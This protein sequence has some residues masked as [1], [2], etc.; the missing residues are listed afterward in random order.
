MAVFHLT[1]PLYVLPNMDIS[2]IPQ[3]MTE[4]AKL[5]VALVD[6][7]FDIVDATVMDSEGSADYLV[8]L[9]N[10][11]LGTIRG[12]LGGAAWQ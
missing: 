10:E 12:H 3:L 11:L 7:K 5:T 4:L 8:Y 6:P 1:H 9:N 2:N